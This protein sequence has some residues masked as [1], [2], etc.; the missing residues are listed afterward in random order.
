MRIKELCA[1]TGQRERPAVSTRSRA[2][3]RSQ[4]AAPTATGLRRIASGTVG[5]RAPLPDAGSSL[6]G[7]KRLLDV[8]QRPIGVYA[9]VDSLVDAAQGES[10]GCHVAELA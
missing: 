2:C 7:V 10:C 5:F 9:D 1:S 6:A 8:V 4:R 3:C